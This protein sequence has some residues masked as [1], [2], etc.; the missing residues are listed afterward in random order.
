[1]MSEGRDVQWADSLLQL[2]R[3]KDANTITLLRTLSKANENLV[4]AEDIERLLAGQDSIIVQ[5]RVQHKVITH[6][7]T[8]VTR[9]KKKGFSV[10]W[11]RCSVRPSKIRPFR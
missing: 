2:L 3:E 8:I 5:H 6:R 7:D 11:V 1:M 9:P 10:V 4:T